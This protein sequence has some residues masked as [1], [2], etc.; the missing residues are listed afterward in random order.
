M[1]YFAR[2]KVTLI[3]AILALGCILAAPN[4]LPARIAD[5]L[6]GALPLHR[7]SLGLDLQGGSS[8]LLAADIDAA[9]HERLNDVVDGIRSELRKA[10]IGYTNLAIQGGTVVLKLRDP[11]SIEAARPLIEGVT[12]GVGAQLMDLVIGPDGTVTASYNKAQIADITQTAIEQSI[13]IV[14]RRIDSTGTREP[15]IQRQGTDRILVQLPGIQDPERVKVLLGKTAKMTFR[16]VDLTVT[17]ESAK[18]GGLPPTSELLPLAGQAG[19]GEPPL[20]VVQKRVL[21]SGE[22]LTDAAPSFNQNGQPDVTFKF[23]SLGAKRFCDATQANVGKPF[24]IVLDNQVISA[25]RINEAICG[26]SGE[27]TGNFTVDSAHELA[28]LLR[29]GALPVPLKIIEERTVGPDLGA[30]SIRAGV[31]ACI[32]GF[33]LVTVYMVAAYGLFG[34]FADVALLFNLILTIGIMSAISATLTLP[35]I[36]GML[37]TLGMSVD[38][39]VLINERIREETKLGRSP[40]AA[41][42]AGFRRAFATIFDANATTLIKMLILYTLGSGPVQGFAVTISLG[43]CTSMFTA[44]LVV[45]WIMSMWLRRTRPAALRV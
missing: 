44:I 31:Y 38:A 16:M 25:P 1:M 12:R 32:I 2:W 6:P 39:N 18:A 28:T 37:L 41:L 19:S 42:D 22:N 20:F 9:I 7:I 15:L 35:G 45:R 43:I 27:I 21:V 4:L 13:E 36:A 29:S 40:I 8:L 26:G 17:P 3:L 14:R 33:A 34:L 5:N 24:A 23:D 30:D 11:T 10:N